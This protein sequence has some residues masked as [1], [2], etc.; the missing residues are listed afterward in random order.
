MGYDAQTQSHPRS[1]P[2]WYINRQNWNPMKI[3]QVIIR[4]PTADGR[5]DRRTQIRK[6]GIQCKPP[7]PPPLNFVVEGIKILIAVG[8]KRYHDILLGAP[9]GNAQEGG[10][11]VMIY[12][13]GYFLCLTVPFC[14]GKQQKLCHAFV[15]CICAYNWRVI[16]SR[17][18]TPCLIMCLTD[19][20]LIHFSFN[21][22]V[23][24]AHVNICDCFGA[25]VTTL[26]HVVRVDD[27]N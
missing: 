18:W 12:S 6:E 20:S 26:Q 21:K 9:G 13:A 15:I 8:R 16:I 3:I 7:P 27:F 24:L 1:S 10:A 2:K 14:C 22:V 23:S 5:T 17:L 4:T 25:N 11:W 19:L